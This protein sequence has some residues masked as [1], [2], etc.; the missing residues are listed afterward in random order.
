MLS[1]SHQRIFGHILKSAYA[2]QGLSHVRTS[3]AG[4]G[5]PSKPA[6]EVVSGFDGPLGGK[7]CLYWRRFFRC[8]AGDVRSQTCA[9][10]SFVVTVIS[11]GKSD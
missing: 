1:R 8:D 3:V 4:W 7:T 11:E 2:H 5:L 9:F 6:S 10:A